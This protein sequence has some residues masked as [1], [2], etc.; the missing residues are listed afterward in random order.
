MTNPKPRTGPI[1]GSQYPSKPGEHIR[2][3]VNDHERRQASL[4]T[5]STWIGD[6]PGRQN[7]HFLDK[8][9]DDVGPCG[10]S[11]NPDKPF[12]QEAQWKY[13]DGLLQDKVDNFTAERII[14]A[15]QRLPTLFSK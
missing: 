15:H 9:E 10:I 1:A 14:H 11:I 8:T 4:L 12:D 5:H 7:C 2:L 3:A 6:P 13:L